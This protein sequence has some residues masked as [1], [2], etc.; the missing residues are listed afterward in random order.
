M[1]VNGLISFKEGGSRSFLE[2]TDYTCILDS[3]NV[4]LKLRPRGAADKVW[5]HT[6]GVKTINLLIPE[7]FL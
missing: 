2:L 3:G 4:W 5:W 6:K 7:V 1:S